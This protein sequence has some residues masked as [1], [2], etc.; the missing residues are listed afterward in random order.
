MLIGLTL[1]LGA[2]AP[3]TAWG[4]IAFTH[5]NVIEVRD[6]ANTARQDR[7]DCGDRIDAVA[8]ATH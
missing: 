3:C 1:L 8:S 4:Q 7:I 5:V 2:A 6:G